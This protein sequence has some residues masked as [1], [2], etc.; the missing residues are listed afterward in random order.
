[1]LTKVCG[2]LLLAHLVLSDCQVRPITE[3]DNLCS[4]SL[5]SPRVQ[6]VRILEDPCL[7]ELWDL[8]DH[9]ITLAL[10][11]VKNFQNGEKDL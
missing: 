1:M 7:I 9:Q 2:V 10:K 11:K 6:L 8:G 5:Q 4:V 3:C